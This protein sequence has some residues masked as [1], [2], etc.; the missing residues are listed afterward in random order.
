MS[1]K[2]KYTAPAILEDLALELEAEILGAS[3]ELK[4]DESI[5]KVETMGQEIG[6][7]V[8]ATQWTQEWK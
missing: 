1:K 3:A 8:D 2:L 6:G 4:V 7:T 5:D